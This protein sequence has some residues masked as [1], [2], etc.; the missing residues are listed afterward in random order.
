MAIS[1]RQHLVKRYYTKG[2]F[3]PRSKDQ[4]LAYLESQQLEAGPAGG[5]SGK[6]T[7]DKKVLEQLA[8]KDP[9]F[10]KV[11]SQKEIQKIESTYVDNAMRQSEEGRRLKYN[12]FHKPSTLRL[13]SAKPFNIQNVPEDKEGNAGNGF[14]KSIVAEE[15]CLLIEADKAAVEAVVTGWVAKAPDYIRLAKLGVHDYIT[16]H[17][18]DKPAHLTWS[19]QKL[20]DYFKWIKE[21]YKAERKLCKTVVHASSYG[22]TPW[23]MVK[24]FPK[25]F[26]VQSAT[27]LQELF[28]KL[29]PEIKH[30]QDEIRVFVHKNGY[31]GGKGMHPFGYKHWFWEVYSWNK[32]KQKLQRGPDHDRVVAYPGQSISAG[33]IKDDAL[34]VATEG[35]PNYIGELGP[36]LQGTKFPIRALIHDSIFCEVRKE[37]LEEAKQ[38]LA[39]AMTRLIP[40]LPCPPSWNLGTHLSIGVSIKVGPNWGE[41]KEVDA[42]LGTASDLKL[43]DEEEES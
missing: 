42:E 22:Q 33:L 21:T 7:L 8:G 10:Q 4:M 26:T 27:K 15:G 38:K 13:S 41:M 35:S 16:S 24:R 37:H 40:E 17:L 23:G 11:L 39:R 9:L 28:F 34:S 2:D 18:V 3:N 36:E 5:K 31:W 12:F 30:F 25:T 14:R 20:G 6:P 1:K 29:C 19:D 32:H 43:L